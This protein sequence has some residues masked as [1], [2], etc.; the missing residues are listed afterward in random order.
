M[1]QTLWAFRWMD[2]VDYSQIAQSDSREWIKVRWLWC[3]LRLT[4]SLAGQQL[5]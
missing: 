2:T 3:W 4:R 1:M 5:P